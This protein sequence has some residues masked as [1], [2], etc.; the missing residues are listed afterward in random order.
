VRDE[1]VLFQAIDGV[2]EALKDED[3]GLGIYSP[4]HLHHMNSSHYITVFR[5]SL[6]RRLRI[7]EKKLKIPEVDRATVERELRTAD[8]ISF[9]AVRLEKSS[10]SLH[11]DTNLQHSEDVRKYF[12][13][14]KTD[15]ASSAA[16]KENNPE[17]FCSF[18]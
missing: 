4:L 1:R 2:R 17:V 16:E 13:P 10:T 15:R 11:L 9:S 8:V 14:A 5:P 12:S 18:S 6:L 7:L 3:T